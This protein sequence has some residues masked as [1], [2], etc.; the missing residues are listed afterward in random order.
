MSIPSADLIKKA[1]A[2]LKQEHEARLSLEK[3][4]E[5]AALEKRATR[6][7]FREVELGLREPFRSYEELTEKVAALVKEGDIASVEKALARG[8]GATRQI[9]ELDTSGTGGRK[10]NPLE[11]WVWNGDAP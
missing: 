3:Q 4:A 9:G 10:L 1:G 11:E 6:V 5:D 8:Y 2:L 7:A